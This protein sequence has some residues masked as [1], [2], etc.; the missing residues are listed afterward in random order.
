MVWLGQRLCAPGWVRIMPQGP[1]VARIHSVTD[2][3]NLCSG[4][5]IVTGS[6]KVM[7]TEET[8]ADEF[9]A[10]VDGRDV[11]D[12]DSFRADPTTSRWEFNF[13][14]PP[15]VT[16]GPHELTVMLGKRVF[17]PIAIEVA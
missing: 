14:L 11:L 1:L 15:E 13:R 4:T 10:T 17:A 8:H 7:M 6:V 3:I 2:G 12:T 5:T 16:R 9:R